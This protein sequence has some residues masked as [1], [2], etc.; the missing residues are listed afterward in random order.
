VKVLNLKLIKADKKDSDKILA[1]Q[2]ICFAPHL[3]RY[4]DFET[5]PSMATTEMIDEWIQNDNFFKICLEGLWIGSINIRKLEGADNYKLHIINI[6]PEYQ[7]RGI[8]Q[9]AIR[10]AEQVFPNAKSW[11]LETLEDMPNNRHVYEKMGYKFTG[12]AERI[13]DNLTIVFYEK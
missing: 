6:L 2:K 4:Q 12:S 1:M 7:N 8:G 10:L 9:A 13:N 5:N 11:C 3:E